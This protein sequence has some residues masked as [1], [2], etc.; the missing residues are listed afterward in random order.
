MTTE[1]KIRLLNTQIEEQFARA[2]DSIARMYELAC[3]VHEHT[4]KLKELEAE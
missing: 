2:K 3:E 1:E 4:K